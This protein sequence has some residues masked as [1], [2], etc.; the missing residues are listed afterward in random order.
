MDASGLGIH[1]PHNHHKNEVNNFN[2]LVNLRTIWL[3]LY[4]RKYI[5]IYKPYIHHNSYLFWTTRRKLFRLFYVVV[6]M[7]GPRWPANTF[8]E[9]NMTWDNVLHDFP[10]RQLFLIELCLICFQITSVD[11]LINSLVNYIIYIQLTI[12]PAKPIIGANFW[13]F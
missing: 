13:I 9:A 12:F 7:E 1:W 5:W 6:H 2:T 11:F 8:M 4:T 10:K 3:Y